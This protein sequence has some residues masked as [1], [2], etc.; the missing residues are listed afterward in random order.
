MVKSSVNLA[1]K[2]Q[3]AKKSACKSCGLYLNQPPLLDKAQ[4]PQVFWV[5]LSAVKLNDGD[6][7]LP[8]ASYTR[9]GELIER[10]EMPLRKETSFYKT[11]LVKCLPLM[12][13]KIRYPV[14]KE[15]EKCFPN[16]EVELE[17]L[18]PSIIFL[19]GKQV[20]TFV[21]KQFT[22]KKV[23]FSP[24]F[25]YKKITVGSITFVPVHHPSYILVY[26]RKMI[27]QYIKN[28]RKIVKL[29]KLGKALE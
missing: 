28:I 20:A 15:M 25:K 17:L 6:I 7:E 12:G 2:L 24:D 5:G 22:D 1:R 11:N 26:K 3:P 29:E 14:K 4:K 23:D 19:L 10:I 13:K 16:F 27:N 18:N 21:L 9:T 8:L